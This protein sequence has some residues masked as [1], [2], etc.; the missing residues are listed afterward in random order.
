MLERASARETAARVAVGAITRQLLRRLDTEI[1]S[2]VVSIGSAG[3]AD[4]LAIAFEDVQQIPEDSSW[5]CVDRAVEQQM[6][7]EIDR[8][9]DAGDT[10]GG[11]FEVIARGVPVGLGSH[12]QWDRK[13]DGRLGQALMSIPAIKAV[14][15][16]RGPDVARLP[17]SRIHDEILPPTGARPSGIGVS[18]PTNNAGGLE[19]GIT[20][21]QDLRVSGYMKPIATLMRPLRS[22]DLTTMEVPVWAKAIHAQGTVKATAGSVNVPVVCA[23]ATIAP[24]D[25]IIGDVSGIPDEIAAVSGWFPDGRAGGPTGAELPAAMLE[26]IRANDSL[27]PGGKLFLPTGTLQAEGRILEVARRIFGAANLQSLLER[28]LPL[29]DVVAKSKAVAQMMKEGILDLHARGSRLLWRLQIWRCEMP[30]DAVTPILAPSLVTQA[31]TTAVSTWA[32]VRSRSIRT[33]TRFSLACRTCEA[34]RPP[35]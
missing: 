12:V 6:I 34:A 4:P 2:H 10:M 15:I 3:L 7:A 33:L 23:G 14:G 1:V 24:G 26:S 17:G 18:R 11:S 31:A 29:P 25:V 8:A 20:N 9:R 22:V 13:L 30:T 28:E 19:G 16:G 21:G 5:H 27:V 35:S 32:R